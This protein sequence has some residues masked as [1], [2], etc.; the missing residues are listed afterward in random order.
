MAALK[1]EG[2][3]CSLHYIPLHMT[4]I[5]REEYGYREEDF[6]RAA[7]RYRSVL[8]LPLYPHLTQ[9]Q[10]ASVV[11]AIERITAAHT[12]PAHQ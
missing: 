2:I 1:R 10:C 5:Y 8:S 4:R 7:A 9:R 3:E 12:C 11:M 6:P